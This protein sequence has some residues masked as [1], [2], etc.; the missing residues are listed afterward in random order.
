MRRLNFNPS[1]PNTTIVRKSRA[2]GRA[3]REGN[4]PDVMCCFACHFTTPNKPKSITPSVHLNW[5]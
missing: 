5:A 2:S 1:F 3:Q 4:D